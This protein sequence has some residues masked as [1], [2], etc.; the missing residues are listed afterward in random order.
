MS[1]KENN[2]EYKVL[3]LSIGQLEELYFSTNFRE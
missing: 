1:I 3:T 2:N